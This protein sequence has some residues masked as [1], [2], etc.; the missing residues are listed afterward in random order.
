L[1]VKEQNR[2]EPTTLSPDVA[3]DIKAILFGSANVNDETNLNVSPLSAKELC[4]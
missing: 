3:P 2:S 4:Y 1:E